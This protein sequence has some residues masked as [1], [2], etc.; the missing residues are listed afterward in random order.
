MKIREGEYPSKN[1]PELF[2]KDPS[3]LLVWFSC[4]AAS[5]VALKLVSGCNPIAVYCD[6]SKDEHPDNERFLRD[7]EEW[8]GIKVMK[9]RS[10]KYSS[11][12]EVFDAKQYM[13][14]PQGAP[15]TV[16]MK[17][18]PRFAFQRPDDIH[19]FG[20][21]ADEH[22]RIEKF[23]ADNHDLNLAWPLRDAGMTKA[24][25]L[26]MVREAGIDLPIKYRK[27]YANNNCDGCVKAT[28]PDYWNLVRKTTPEVFVRRCE[29]S[30]RLGVKLVRYKGQRIFLDELPLDADEH[31][32]EDLSCGPQCAPNSD[33]PKGDA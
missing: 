33:K 19:V 3:R 29:Q 9:I 25:C 12:E 15:C 10:A 6:L 31:I 2:G 21:S 27:G 26:S 11:I 5:A 14:G 30:R 7:V 20:L 18:V 32:Q 28:S 1:Q 16:A 23:E 8:T 17:K 4:G 24:D 22:R 13:S